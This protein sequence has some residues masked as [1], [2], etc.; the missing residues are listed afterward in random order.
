MEKDR[1]SQA[2]R[3]LYRGGTGQ[4]FFVQSARAGLTSLSGL[5]PPDGF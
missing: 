1:E 2:H 4:N 3:F 5:V